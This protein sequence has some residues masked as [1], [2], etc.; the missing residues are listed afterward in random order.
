MDDLRVG[1][2]IRNLTVQAGFFRTTSD[3]G[4]QIQNGLVKI[5]DEA[6]TNAQTMLNLEQLNSEGVIKLSLGKKRHV[7][8]KPQ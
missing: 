6:V 4:K 2:N 5:N 3:A 7:L 1:I 8:I